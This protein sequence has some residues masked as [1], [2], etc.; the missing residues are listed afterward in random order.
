MKLPSVTIKNLLEAGVHL[1]Q[2][3]GWD[4]THDLIPY[5]SYEKIRPNDV[6]GENAAVGS[7]SSTANFHDL[8]VGVSYKPIDAV[9]LKLDYQQFFYD[10][11]V[12]LLTDPTWTTTNSIV[13]LGV[14]Y[15][16]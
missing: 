3:L 14:A 7:V 8:T 15:Q 16:Y 2:L 11:S 12:D 1:P 5:I 10:E 9:A 13:N 6:T 4:T